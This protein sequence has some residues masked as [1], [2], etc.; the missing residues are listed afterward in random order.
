MLI[1]Y[2]RSNH[3]RD[4]Y[5]LPAGKYESRS[6]TCIDLGILNPEFANSQGEVV[7]SS[8]RPWQGMATASTPRVE[9]IRPI[10]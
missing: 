3:G 8:I 7:I 4:Y 2:A 1:I 5:L 6:S 9:K 10:G